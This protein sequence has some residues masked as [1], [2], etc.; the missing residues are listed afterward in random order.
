MQCLGLMRL[1]GAQAGQITLRS[2]LFAGMAAGR[3]L[4]QPPPPAA[5]DRSPA[6]LGPRKAQR[7]KAESQCWCWRWGSAW[8][9]G[10]CPKATA[11]IKGPGSTGPRLQWLMTCLFRKLTLM[12]P[13]AGALS[14]ELRKS[15]ALGQENGR[16]SGLPS[17]STQLSQKPGPGAHA[18]NSCSPPNTVDSHPVLKLA[19]STGSKVPG[20]RDA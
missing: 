4:L 17:H 13:Q 19:H 6:L 10:M 3:L 9:C 14:Q 7:Q 1:H 8:R 2:C 11:E 12:V 16:F 5:E 15:L 18:L 20:R